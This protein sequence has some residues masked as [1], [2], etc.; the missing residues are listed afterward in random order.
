M[1]WDELTPEE[2]QQ[3]LLQM[4]PIGISEEESISIYNSNNT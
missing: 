1:P 3:Y 2:Q 4:I